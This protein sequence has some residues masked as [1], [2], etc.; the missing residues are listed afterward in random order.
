MAFFAQSVDTALGTKSIVQ[1]NANIDLQTFGLLGGND[2]RPNH[3]YQFN[4]DAAETWDFYDT[5]LNELGIG[6][7]LSAIVDAEM[8]LQNDVLNSVTHLTNSQQ[9]PPR[10]NSEL[11]RRAFQDEVFQEINYLRRSEIIARSLD[12]A[13][14]TTR[15]DYAFPR[16]ALLREQPD[17]TYG[18]ELKDVFYD[19]FVSVRAQLSL[20]TAFAG[21]RFSI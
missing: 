2:I 5:L 15:S 20:S 17:Q 3:S 8:S 1:F 21:S 7:P 6:T 14:F 4:H 19:E 18:Q 13:S 11:R 9:V 10:P 12:D 16:R